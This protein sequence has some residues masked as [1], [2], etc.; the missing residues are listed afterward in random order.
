MQP[1]RDAVVMAVHPKIDVAELTQ[2]VAWIEGGEG[3]DWQVLVPGQVGGVEHIRRAATGADQDHGILG[4]GVDLQGLGHPVL[5]AIIVGETG[6]EVVVIEGN[7]AH[8]AL[9]GEIGS[10]VAGD[11][12]AAAVANKDDLAGAEG[13]VAADITE[14][15][16]GVLMLRRRQ[17]LGNTGE[18]AIDEVVITVVVLQQVHH[19][20]D[21]D[22]MG[23]LDDI[24][25]IAVQPQARLAER[26]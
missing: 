12:G 19:Q 10:G 11:G 2:G 15:E 16:Q 9:L 18:A 7:G 13:D 8:P 23:G 26:A 25:G 5:Q 20:Q 21:P 14:G 1:F 6:Q 3:D 4:L 22:Q 24:V 17:R